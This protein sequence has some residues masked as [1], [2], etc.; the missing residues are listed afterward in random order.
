MIFQCLCFS[1]PRLTKALLL[2][3][4]WLPCLAAAADAHQQELTLASGEEITAEVFGRDAGGA[5]HGLRVLW[6]APN[7]GLHS[8]HRQLAEALGQR[9]LEVWQVD[10]AESLF[11]TKSATTMREIPAAFVADIITALSQAGQRQIVIISSGYGAIPALR[12]IHAWQSR[13]PRQ[14]TVVGAILF[15]P[16]LFTQVPTLGA[17]PAFVPE[18][19]ANTAP[20]Y[21]FQAAKNGSRWHLP[22]LLT[23]LQQHAPVYT[24]ILDGVTSLFHDKDAAP[25]TLAALKAMPDKIVRA[26]RQLQH[27]PIPLQAL[28]LAAAP[29]AHG[30]GLDTRLK[31][32]GGSVVPRGFA[33]HDVNGKPFRV[34]DFRGRVT[35]INFWASWCPPCVKEIPSLNRLKQ[36]MQGKP[37]QLISIN[38]AETPQRIREFMQKA[39]V[40][41]PVLVDPEGRLTGQ[42]QVVA[43]PSTFVIGPDGKIQYG[44]NAAI[45][46]DTDEV[47]QQLSAILATTPAAH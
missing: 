38:Y 44:V 16:H 2:L 27:H 30:S 29:A 1:S 45:H 11:L 47:V 19:A 12:G 28:P 35:L 34:E 23:A 15:S 33:L 24:E 46:W 20:L 6:I 3:L 4:F 36:R 13:R 9:G 42:W 17:A 31:A 7:F 32:Y 40:D 22:A 21:I 10:L 43:F 5:A 14:A 41:F 8:R 39:A 26:V 18:V 25:Q 37:F